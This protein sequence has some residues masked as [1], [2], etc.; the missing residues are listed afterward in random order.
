MSLR[1]LTVIRLVTVTQSVALALVCWLLGGSSPL[2]AQNP[3]VGADPAPASSFVG[4]QVCFG[5]PLTHFGTPPGFGPYL[6]LVLEPGLAFDSATLFG[7]SADLVAPTPTIVPGS[8]SV[9]DPISG[10]AITAPAGYTVVVARLPVGSVVDGG[11]TLLPEICLTVDSG[12]DPYDPLDFSVIPAYEFG[13]SATGTPIV[14]PA[15]R[16][17]DPITPTIARLTKTNRAAEFERAPGPTWPYEYEIAIDIADGVTLSTLDILDSPLPAGLTV[18]SGPTVVGGTGCIVNGTVDID[19]TSATGG[20]GTGDVVVTYEVVISDILDED[21]CDVDPLLNTASFDATFTRPSDGAVIAISAEEGG[22]PDDSTTTSVEHVVV[23]KGVVQGTALPGETLDYSVNIEVTD[24]DDVAAL[25]YTD[26]LPDGTGNFV[27]GSLLIGGA[28][29]AIVPATSAGPG[30]GQT[31]VTYD[32]G[33]AAT[34]AAVTI[35]AGTTLSIAYVADVLQAYPGA[36]GSVLARDALTNGGTITFDLDAGT[37]AACTNST[38]AT[39]TIQ[40]VTIDKSI[41]ASTPGPYQSGDLVTYVIGMDIPSGDVDGIELTDF[42]PLPVFDA[43]DAAFGVTATFGTTPGI[44]FGPGDD[45]GVTP[46]IAV[47]G[48]T[49]SVLLTVGDV[50]RTTPGRIE[51]EIDILVNDVPFADGLLLQNLY[52]AKTDNTGDD[53]L[54]DVQPTPITLEAPT[55]TLTKGILST[56]GDGN[57]NPGPG[58]QPVDGDLTNADAG[59][60]VTFRIT[61]ENT[62]AAEAYNVAISDPAIPG[63]LAGCALDSVSVDGTTLTAGVD[64]TG[65]LFSSALELS[66]DLLGVGMGSLAANDQSPA[67]GGAPYSDD[68]ALIEYTCTI[69]AA[70][71]PR[72]AET[73]TAS[74]SWTSGPLGTTYAPVTDDAEVS[75]TRPGIS[76]ELL[77][78]TPNQ[79]GA[80]TTAHIGEVLRYRVILDIPEGTMT[81][82]RFEDVLDQGLAFVGV[83]SVTPS[84]AALL[85]DGGA[86]CPTGTVGDQGGGVVNEGRRLDIPLGTLTNTDT[87]DAVAETIT[88]V[89]D[90]VLLNW[91]NND[92]GDNRN[93]RAR[94]YHANP[95]GGGEVFE[96]RRAPNVN[97]VEPEISLGKDIS[98]ALGMA[99]T[100]HTVTLT[101]ANAAP[102]NA[103]AYDVELVDD[104][105][106]VLPT[107][108]LNFAGSL[109]TGTC[110]NAPTSLAESGGV[111]TATWDVL[112]LGG[113]CEVTFEVTLDGSVNPGVTYDNLASVVWES[114]EADPVGAQTA[115]N[116]LSTERT[117][118]PAENPSDPGANDQRATASDDV[119][120]QDV[121]I[122][123]TFLSSTESTTDANQGDGSLNDLTVGEVVTFRLT[124]VVPT[125]TIPSPGLIVTDSLPFT[126]GTLEAIAGTATT[127]PAGAGITVPTSTVALQDIAPTDGTND[128]VRFEFGEV[129]NSSGSDIVFEL[130]VEAVV[131]ELPQNAGI[132]QV[133]NSALVQFGPG[134]DGSDTLDVEIVEPQLRM[135]KTGDVTVAD[136]GDVVTFQLLVEHLPSS[137]ADA[138]DVAIS[139]PLIVGELSPVGSPSVVGGSC[140]DLPDTGPSF[141]GATVVAT[142]DNFPLGASCL[143]EYQASLDA[144]LSP[145]EGI[146]N[147]ADLAWFSLDAGNDPEGER[148]SYVDESSWNISVSEPGVVKTIV[149]STVAETEVPGENGAS[150]DLTIGEEVTFQMTVTL[151]DA[152]LQNAA[153]AD[154][155]PGVGVQL[156]YVSSQIVSIGAD[157]SLSSGLTVGSAATV[158]GD[159]STWELGNVTNTPDTVSTV[160]EDNEIVFEVV[161]LVSDDAANQ[162]APGIDVAELNVGTLTADNLADPISGSV[163]IDIVEPVLTI[164]KTPVGGDPLIVAAGDTVT[165][166]LTVTHAPDSTA[167]AF[168]LVIEDSLTAQ[169]TLV[170]LLASTTCPGAAVGGGPAGPITFTVPALPLSL[171]SC[172]IAYD[173]LVSAAAPAGSFVNVADLTYE[174][175]DGGGGRQR[176]TSDDGTLIRPDGD[177][178]LLKQITSTNNPDTPGTEVAIGELITYTLTATIPE[179][180]SGD[181]EIVDTVDSTLLRVVSGR[182]VSLGNNITTALPGTPTISGAAN[183]TITFDFDVVTNVA[184]LTNDTDDQILVEVTAVVTDVA[185]NEAGDFPANTAQITE[186]GGV[187]ATSVVDVEIVEPELELGKD[188]ELINGRIEIIFDVENTGSAPIYDVQITD[189]LDDTWFVQGSVLPVSLPPGWSV[190]ETTATPSASETTVTI[191]LSSPP[192]AAPT[193][194]QVIAIDETVFFVISVELAPG[195]TAADLPVVNDDARVEGTSMPGPNPDERVGDEGVPEDD[196]FDTASDALDIPLL[197]IEKTASPAAATAGQTV[198]YT[199]TVSNVG[200]ADANSVTVSDTG[201]VDNLAMPI[202][203]VI[204]SVSAPTGAV[205][206]GN[207]LGDSSIG[208][209]FATVA[210]SGSA[211]LTFDVSVPN[212]LAAGVVSM[213]NQAT[214]DSDETEPQPSDDDLG[215]AT[216]NTPTT[217]PLLGAPDLAISKDDG[218]A[219]TAPGSTVT[220]TLDYSNIG[221]QDATG[222]VLTETVPA[223]TTSGTNAGWEVAPVGSGTPCSG[224]AAGTSCVLSVGPLAGGAPGNAGSSGSVTFAVVVDSPL[225]GGVTEIANA[226]QIADD[227][228]NGS[229]PDTTNNMDPDTTPVAAAPDLTIT[230][231]DG[232]VSTTAG[233][234]VTYALNFSNVGPQTATGVVL[235]ETVPANTT[236]AT[237][238][239]WE[240]APVGSG[241]PCSG[242]PAGT[243]CVLS[244]GSVA[245]GGGSGSAAFSVVVEDPLASGVTEIANSARVDDDG[246]NGTDPTPG[247]NADPDTTP[248]SSD[249][250]LV[251]TKDDG[252]VS[253]T[254]GGVVT[255]TLNYSNI[256]SQSATGVFLTETVP[257]DTTSGTN[258]GWEVSPVGSA[259]PCDAQ[260]AGTACVLS[261]GPLAGSGGSGAAT[262]QIVVE[263]PVSAG[264]DDVTNV[265]QIGDDGANGPD[266]DPMNNSG[267]DDTPIDATPD[268]VITKDDG[269]LTLQPGATISYALQI[270]NVGSQGA[271]GVEITETV[272]DDTTFDAGSSTGTWVCTPDGS[273][274][275]TCVLSIGALDAGDTANFTFAVTIDDP[276]PA[277]VTEIANSAVVADD[278]A[279]GPDPT[280]VDNEDS[281]TTPVNGMPV[282]ESTKSDAVTNDADGSGTLTP[283]DTITY[284]VNLSATGNAGTQAV[285][286]TDVPDP[287]TTLTAGSVTTTQGTITLG[288]GAGNTS[289]TVD[290]GDIASGVTVTITFDVTLN[291]PLPAGLMVISNQGVADT[292]DAPG[293]VPTD[294]PD[295]PNPDDPTDTP[296]V[297]MPMLDGSKTVTLSDDAD[298][299]MGVT[300]GDTLSYTVVVSNVGSVGATNVSFADSLDPNTAL[301]VGS[302]ASDVGTVAIGNTNGDVMVAVAIGTLQAGDV[303]TITFDVTVN[304]PL[305]PENVAQILNQGTVSA[306]DVPDVLT[307]DPNPPGTDD[308]TSIP[309][310][311]T[312]LYSIPTMGQWGLLLLIGLL[313]LT[314]LV[315]LRR[316]GA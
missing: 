209:L 232:G 307:D 206:S 309:V 121:S 63:F 189:V 150:E 146:T 255:Y 57:V 42:F 138:F 31:T 101:V 144:A 68:A 22:R 54:R 224:Q 316:L 74:A 137:S 2:A 73:N 210:S 56:D 17:D 41:S 241:T 88:I 289:L 191:G 165:F 155:L 81:G 27:H 136:G 301:V 25:V 111:I 130:D 23:Q 78:I 271:T 65:D 193:P 168:D 171:M 305:V 24:F 200:T 11:P 105:N 215:D 98:P 47:D 275:S 269:G 142:F 147:T 243:S 12:V 80:G 164:D 217:V 229:D 113:S 128:T 126:P 181:V 124:V 107:P 151:P 93:N 89:Y 259:V 302:V 256:G 1:L 117:G 298:S 235:T 82:A 304:D 40:D 283:G 279:N 91:S 254:P 148:R 293:G 100:T 55:L 196:L 18:I 86:C 35:S 201:P 29:V 180:T 315:Q 3:V 208:A 184:D 214:A 161:A 183:D 205:T 45:V 174:S 139:D 287:N 133:T 34:A 267:A 296:V 204:G 58:S 172:T 36:G 202:G 53:G 39:T 79:T 16:V 221:N 264:S 218:G 306:D 26:I 10:T 212:P 313:S 9:T 308:P 203:W 116:P 106:G 170:S 249:V 195:L 187:E 134:L 244:I 28:S 90:A 43:D 182:V 186:D 157:L 153:F 135:T 109:T 96:Q 253:T 162:G 143:I 76:K 290:V 176:T 273:A 188:M 120:V 237:N 115:N 154:D 246:A 266:A 61:V 44:R 228:A 50:S 239:G 220:Y 156:D 211:S 49:N 299:S 119:K 77:S 32:I 265:A 52:E 278:G 123:K 257:A 152:F 178:D 252:G 292:P 118:D 159:P 223:N 21:A 71:E 62:G 46:G 216:P 6:Q 85:V 145:G 20:P 141:A 38:A 272:P 198:T 69:A 114:L 233:G 4:E 19:C 288:N 160:P 59:D 274:G 303:A 84:S 104:L 166:E 199:I 14:Y 230:K 286:F 213:T 97:I 75:I 13:N 131:L 92:R 280:P 207:T 270:D 60:Q 284:T 192:V 112:P 83:V 225:P 247:N 179:G 5:V 169:T 231:E 242:Q 227:G 281:D 277:G 177:F 66:D 268:L 260:P 37:A 248:V 295:T 314:G 30:P 261:V 149:S 7:V 310:Q 185:A 294:D 175:L 72:Q 190:S 167:D 15:N 163:P 48:P 173:V 140:T 276:L 219:T 87:D 132:T 291:A 300:S 226:A 311:P 51:Y 234:T 99:G 108:L 158:P 129:V 122:S 103:T 127:V 297:L 197:E 238:A 110:P 250:D 8:G 258:P 282:L 262:F 64:Y 194:D 236:S 263:D 312:D 222:V 240:V 285:V 95:N 102:S 70:A 94:I 245:G 125:G 67:G 33:A 251:I